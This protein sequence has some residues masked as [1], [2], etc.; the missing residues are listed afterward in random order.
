MHTRAVVKKWG[1]SLG[2]RIPAAMANRQHIAEGCEVDLVE[3]D[4]QI[5]IR[6]EPEPTLKDLLAQIKP[7]DRPELVDWG[8]SIGKEVW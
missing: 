3:Q 2:I 8:K 5:V 4:N 1:N 7:G 6:P